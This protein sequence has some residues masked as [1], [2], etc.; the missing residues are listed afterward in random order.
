MQPDGI[1][2]PHHDGRG[3]AKEN[4]GGPERSAEPAHGAVPAHTVRADQRGLENEEDNPPREYGRMNPEEQGPRHS[5]MEETGVDGVAEAPDHD[6]CD[7]QRH[8]EIEIPV[9]QTVSASERAA[10]RTRERF[11]RD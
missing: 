3:R 8:G 9:Q 10:Q 11:L 2:A 4:H 1:E 6:R 7:E 5:G